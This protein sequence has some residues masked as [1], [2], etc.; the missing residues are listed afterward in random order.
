MRDLYETAELWNKKG[1]ILVSVPV[2]GMRDLY[3]PPAGTSAAETA[4]SVP[5][6]GMRDLYIIND[7]N[8]YCREAFPSP[9][10]E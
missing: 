8:E 10:G 4:V 6:R 5:V 1:G 2:R 7:S 3:F 9:S